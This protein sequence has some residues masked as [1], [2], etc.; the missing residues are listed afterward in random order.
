MYTAAMKAPS[1]A[2]LLLGILALAVLPLTGCAGAARGEKIYAREKCG[3]CHRFRGE[4][5]S[6][7]PD[8]TAV[9]ERRSEE[10]IKRQILTPEKNS[11]R[12]R[13]PAYPHLSGFE[14]R[15]LV[16]YLGS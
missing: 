5:G 14:V 2:R 13:M 12:H 10:W 9:A 6:L 4:G 3:N 11:P 1:A 16:I 15:S 7:G 8:L